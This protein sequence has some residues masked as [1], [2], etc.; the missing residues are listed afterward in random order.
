M[1][2]KVVLVPAPLHIQRSVGGRCCTTALQCVAERL[3]TGSG[4]VSIEAFG[5]SVTQGPGWDEV[6]RAANGQ[7]GRPKDGGSYPAALHRAIAR[8]WPRANHTIANRGKS[9]ASIEYLSAC[10]DRMLPHRAADL[11]LLETTDNLGF[12]TSADARRHFGDIIDA[13]LARRPG[14]AVILVS[15]FSVSCALRLLRRRQ[16]KALASRDGVARCFANSSL[17]SVLE[18][19]AEER[20]LPIV[21]VRDGLRVELQAHED[22]ARHRVLLKYI[23]E[24]MVHPTLAGC[25]MLAEAVLRV[26]Q[27]AARQAAQPSS[28]RRLDCVPSSSIERTSAEAVPVAGRALCAFGGALHPLVRRARGWSYV[29]ER[30]SQGQPKPG[31]AAT[32]P[33]AT[34]EVCHRDAEAMWQFGYL[35]SYTGMGIARGECVSGCSCRPREWNAHRPKMQ[36]SQ[37]AISKLQ[38]IRV[39]SARKSPRGRAP[40]ETSPWVGCRCVIRLTLT[41]QTS[42]GGHK[43]K[44]EALFGAFA[45]YNT[46]Y[47]V[48]GRRLCAYST[49][50]NR[51]KA[52]A[53][54]RT[55]A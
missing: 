42:S 39:G 34:L 14:V 35:R 17:P 26:L 46:N 20:G 10:V 23:Q 11:Y 19:L 13:V 2:R 7:I 33:G 30:S 49:A 37:T 27:E 48:C 5:T 31:Y 6:D 16:F 41:N 55:V 38:R 22:Q 18:E 32:A 47:A 51:S 3:R 29:V 1:P 44:L 8:H 40:L 21:S 12:T 4:P 24:D 54:S 9:G 36:V 25:T 15:P 45:M 43:F 50:V 52:S 53:L 28:A